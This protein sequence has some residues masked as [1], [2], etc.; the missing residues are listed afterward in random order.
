MY[1]RFLQLFLNKQIEHLSEVNVVYDT[2]SHTKKNFANMR[3]QGKDFSGTVTLLFSSMLA[4]QADICEGS[5]QSTDPQHTSTS[6][7]PSNE[8]PITVSSSSQPKKTYRPRKAK[9]ATEISQSS[10]PIP[11]VTDETITKERED[12]IERVATTTSS[13][14]AEQ[15]SGNINRTQSMTTLNEP[16]PQEIGSGSGPRCQDTIL[17]DA[18]A[19]TRFETTSKQSN[20]PPLLKS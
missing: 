8:E 15:D 4:Q 13:L 1:L 2:P 16:S 5:G 18:E 11:L 20:D 6:V 9:R 7:Q 12:K 17:G 19:Q 14:E 10:G 3:R